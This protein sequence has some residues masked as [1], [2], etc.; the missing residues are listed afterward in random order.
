M[1]AGEGMSTNVV[2]HA[3]NQEF[4]I[5]HVIIEGRENKGVFLKRRLKKLGL[6]TVMGQILFR[7]LIQGWLEKRST[8][9][10]REILTEHQL[11]DAPIPPGLISHVPSVNHEEV[12]RLLHE[13]KPDLVVVSGTRIIADRILQSAP[14]KFINTHAGITP[15]YRGVHGTYW[16]LASND[17]ANSG[18]TVHFVDAGIDTGNIIYQGVVEP[19][20]K[21]NF[22][23]YQ[24]LQ[25][26]AGV[27]ILKRAVRDFCDG[28]IQARA[29]EGESRLW[30]HP[31]LGQYLFNWVFRGIR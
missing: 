20:A 30:Y 25:L 4:G 21:D 19:T 31:T 12:T 3:L 16:A 6:V 14:C 15:K 8:K 17:A 11:N 23:T 2:F 18:V 13:W 7:V 5:T 26:A 9:R 27:G 1:L 29:K 24:T 28:T 10:V 22:A